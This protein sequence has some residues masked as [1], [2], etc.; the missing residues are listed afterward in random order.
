[1]KIWARRLGI[2]VG[3]LVAMT[4]ADT[5]VRILAAALLVSSKGQRNVT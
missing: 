5:I 2:V 3:I 4:V 1:M